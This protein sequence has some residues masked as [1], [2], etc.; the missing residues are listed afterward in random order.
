MESPDLPRVFRNRRHIPAR[1]LFETGKQSVAGL[2][3][4][5]TEP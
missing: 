3:A 1:Y 2:R 5:L 4:E